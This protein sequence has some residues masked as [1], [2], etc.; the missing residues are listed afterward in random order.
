MMTFYPRLLATLFL[1]AS[2]STQAPLFRTG[3]IQQGP[4]APQSRNPGA[5]LFD[6]DPNH[7][8]NRV[9]RCLL[10]RT[11]A[12][13]TGSGPELGEETL[14]PLL[15][16]ETRHLLTGDSHRRAVDCLDEFVRSHAEHQIEDPLKR[17][18]MLRDLWAVFDWSVHSQGKYESQRSEL[19]ARLAEVM[20]HL[21][22][23]PKQISALPDN[24]SQAI[25]AK[26][27]VADFDPADPQ[28]PFL[29]PDLFNSSGPWVGITL[30]GYLPVATV[31]VHAFDARSRFLVFIRL[32][33]GRAAT[34]AYLQQLWAFPQPLETDV[35]IPNPEFP[36]FPA[37]T[38]VALLR[39]MNL[40]DSN[41]KLVATPITES[42]QIRVFRS[43]PTAAS[44]S[45]SD[46]AMFEFRFDRRALF[47]GKPGLLPVGRDEKEF[48]VFFSHGF[49]AFETPNRV[50]QVQ[51]MASC[52]ACHADSG[53]HS[54]R[55]SEQMVRMR[56]HAAKDVIDDPRYGPVY[57]ETEETLSFKQASYDWGLLNGF[58]KAQPR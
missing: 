55:S 46:Q 34:L 33:G 48:P 21:A 43:I 11:S 12:G 8:W 56:E 49:D 25:K 3:G 52:S 44:F 23:T 14:D 16:F 10:A 40:F 57:W 32:P 9:H 35:G 37:G 50:S 45:P 30:R 18:I 51:I 41:G 53:I 39:Q 29:P 26:T 58:W 7:P 54:V 20:R 31:H 6:A 38:M 13:D 2:V 1:A 27:F 24:Y 5:A 47:S 28:R 15:W 19:Q 22:P 4:N 17:A 36:Q 42:L